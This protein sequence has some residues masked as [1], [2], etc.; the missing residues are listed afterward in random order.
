MPSLPSG[1]TQRVCSLLLCSLESA[2]LSV[3]R[4]LPHDTAALVLW[5]QSLDFVTLSFPTS[6]STDGIF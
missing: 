2:S 1:T 5:D 4:H 3:E 6:A